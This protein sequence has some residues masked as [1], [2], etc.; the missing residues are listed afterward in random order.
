MELCKAAFRSF[1]SKDDTEALIQGLKVVSAELGMAV[2]GLATP[3]YGAMLSLLRTSVDDLGRHKIKLIEEGMAHRP[4]LL[5][6]LLAAVQAV[7][8]YVPDNVSM[9]KIEV[10]YEEV[11][12]PSIN[13]SWSE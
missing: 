10:H 6:G 1:M 8:Q 13:L 3:M 7:K 9:P 2:L 4:L 12:A 11:H 5:N